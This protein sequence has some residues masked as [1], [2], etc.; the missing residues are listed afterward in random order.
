MPAGPN[1]DAYHVRRRLEPDDVQVLAAQERGLGGHEVPLAGPGPDRLR[2]AAGHVPGARGAAEGLRGVQRRELSRRSSRRSSRAGRTRRSRSGR[3]SRTPTRGASGTSSTRPAK[4]ETTPTPRS[5]SSSTKRPRRPTACSPR[6]PASRT[7]SGR[8]GRA[9]APPVRLS[10]CTMT[11]ITPT[12]PAPTAQADR[13]A[14][15]PA[16]RSSLQRSRRRLIIGLVAPAVR[17]HGARAPAADARRRLPLVQEPQHVHVRA[18]VRRAVGRVRQLPLDPLRRRQPAA[19][20]V[21]GRR[22]EHDR[23]HVLGRARAR[24]AAGSPWR[25]C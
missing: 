10:S 22:P 23:L 6:R 3:A 4:G 17:V 8:A 9:A 7:S 21:H 25:C 11:T 19:Q 12:E 15:A 5:R 2:E 20:R 16:A 1:G 18:A 24:S 14:A 13:R